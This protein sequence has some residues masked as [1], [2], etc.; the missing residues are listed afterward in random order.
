MVLPASNNLCLFAGDAST[1][2]P[3][4]SATPFPD[5]LGSRNVNC[6][7]PTGDRQCDRNLLEDWYKL[8]N[9]TMVTQCPPAGSCGVLYPIWINGID[10]ITLGW[11]GILCKASTSSSFDGIKCA[12]KTMVCHQLTI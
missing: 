10:S 8:G 9:A 11:P 1:N 12:Y 3:C 7:P 2:D 4:D 5:Y 6:T